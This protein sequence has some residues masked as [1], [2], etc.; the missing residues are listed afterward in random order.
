MTKNKVRLKI[1][2]PVPIGGRKP[3]EEFVVDADDDGNP[4]DQFWRKRLAEEAAYDVGAVAIIADKGGAP[5]AADA[6]VSAPPPA[7]DAGTVKKGGN[8]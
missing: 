2:G 1:I 5:V 4:C 7:S 8:K 6:P 3:K